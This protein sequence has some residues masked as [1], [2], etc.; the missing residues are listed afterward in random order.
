[1]AAQT[2]VTAVYRADTAAYVRG[3]KQAVEATKAFQDATVGADKTLGGIKGSTIAL[4]AAFGTLGA[5]AIAKAT[6]KLKQFT[7]QAID[8]AASYEQT[9]IS[10]EGIFV[11]MGMSVQEATAETKTYLADLRDFAATTPFELPQTL[12]AVK[13]LLSIGYAA[14]DV[15]DRLLPAIGDITSALGQPASAINAVVYAM[16][17]IKSAGRVMQQDLMQIGN[18]LPGFNA[19][20]A[21]AKELFNGDMNSMAQAVQEGSLT[22]EKAIEALISQMQKFP[23]AAGAME[24]QSKTLNGVISTFKDTINNAMIDALIPTMPVLSSALEQLV[25]PVSK[26]AIAFTSQLGPTLV[27]VAKSAQEFAPQLSEMASA[28]MELAGTAITRFITVMGSLAPIFTVAA[29]MLTGLGKVLQSLP[30]S[31]LA[32]TAA[33]LLLMRVGIGKA[34]ITAVG[35]ATIGIATLGKT[36]TTT[37]ATAG[38]GFAAIGSSAVASMT[39]VTAATRV[40][41]GAMHAFKAALSST[42]IGL[43]VVGLATA[44]TALTLSSE[45][46]ATAADTL[47]DSLHDQTGALVENHRALIANAMEQDGI[48]EA[49]RAAG[50]AT[51]D[52]V[53]AY[54]EGGDALSGYVDQMRGYVDASGAMGTATAKA[55]GKGGEVLKQRREEAQSVLNAADALS[56]YVGKMD[57]SRDAI[58]RQ[59]EAVSGLPP[60]Y[61]T[62]E[63]AA[64]NMNR[65]TLRAAEA[66]DLY[67]PATRGAAAATDELADAAADAAAAVEA[68]RAEQEKWLAVT[69]QISAVDAAAAAI[70][71]IGTSAVENANKLVGT[72][73]KIRAFR[74]DVISAFEQSAAVAS[75]LGGTVE[76]QRQIFT[77]ELVKIVAALRASKVKDS[78]IET[79]LRAMDNLPTSVEQIMTAAGVAVGKGSKGFKTGLQKNIEQAFKDSVAAGTPMTAD[80][81]ARMAQSAT[82]AAK[83]EMGLT[84][85]PELLSVIN[86]ASSALQQ[87]AKDAGNAPGYN[88]STGIAAGIT[89]GSPIVVLA[90]QRVIAAAKAAAD[91]A[92][93]SKSPSRLFAKVG[94]NLIQGLRLGWTRGSKDFVDGIAR[95]MQDAF[96]ALKDSKDAIADA[97][98]RLKEIREA[99]N[100]GEASAREVAAAERDLARA[101]RDEADAERAAAEARKNLNATRRLDKM[102]PIKVNWGSLLEE[103]NKSGDVS[104]IFDTLSDK[105]FDKAMRAGMTPE[106]A[107]AY[108]DGIIGNIEKKLA[109]KLRRLDALTRKLGEIRERLSTF[110]E[111]ADERESARKTLADFLADRFGEPSEF[112]KAYNSAE[113]SVDQAIDLFDRAKELIEQRLGGGEGIGE[114]DKAKADSLVKYVEDQT[115]A[116]VTLIKKRNTLLDKINVESATLKDLEDKRN[117]AQEKFTQSIL[118]FSKISGKVGSA[119]EYIMGLEQRVAATRKYIADIDALRKRGVAESVIQQILAAGP[120]SGG[121]FAA[122]LAAATDEQLQYVNE[123]TSQTA[124]MAESFGDA[125]A[126]VMYDAGITAQRALVEGL[127]TEYTTV[128]NEMDKIVAGIEAALAPLATTGYTAGDQLLAST[129]QGLKDREAEILA[130]IKRIGEAIQAAWAAAMTP[131]PGT[132]SA[133][134]GPNPPRGKGKGRS[135]MITAP[136]PVIP[137]STS[138]AISVASGGVQ[139]AVT[140]GA[141][142]NPAAASEAVKSAVMEALSEVA[143][144]AANARR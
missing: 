27:Q 67:D 96:W 52:L 44:I 2:E 116:L 64:G 123:L 76:E 128:V 45:E 95:T 137:Y 56:T 50:I 9:V 3:V 20:M 133:S 47:T 8:A 26:L 10:I 73:P 107:Q 121:T 1:V 84:L 53:D 35:S 22:G 90:V 46:A 36:T 86:S 109:R 34:F 15:K 28:L 14:D 7:M 12:D 141:D 143:A 51:N 106:A 77:G 24:R 70:D 74:G 127:Q 55:Y 91:A 87:P 104:R 31:V 60:V 100:K 92:S 131:P 32:A 112:E 71:N 105:L 88:F 72:S 5:M 129:I 59:R 38:G 37:A 140:V 101:Y 108:V 68:M 19:R 11:G 40:A 102:K 118:D 29:K 42:G 142:Q 39:T 79:F 93:Q 63:V 120:E 138:P 13:R 125:Q 4:G 75:E 49:A 136:A 43:L 78:D 66:A 23:G 130:E 124:T 82:D 99:R 69:G 113:L 16:G 80:A 83:A 114:L 115:Q 25:D 144:K 48:L 103:F 33:M 65:A 97:K 98:K 81:M 57:D 134:G 132:T 18:A 41:A 21:I 110:Q 89:E 94:D 6:S 61:A 139:V 135:A 62:A 17:Q 126:A 122:A 58:E 30:D 85:E 54:I 119:Q 111:I 117:Q